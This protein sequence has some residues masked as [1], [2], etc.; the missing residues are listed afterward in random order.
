MREQRNGEAEKERVGERVPKEV[1]TWRD[2]MGE[3]PLRGTG[4]RG[5]RRAEER[6][7]G[8]ALM[9]E[10]P[11][12]LILE[13][14]GAADVGVPSLPGKHRARVQPGSFALCSS[15]ACP[16]VSMV[17]PLLGGTGTPWGCFSLCPATARGLG[18][19]GAGNW[20]PGRTEIGALWLLLVGFRASPG[21]DML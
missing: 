8:C 5:G 9:L 13:E 21:S 14:L 18:K 6:R 1:S 17:C 16:L 7:A 19:K 12:L 3:T 2:Q 11:A 4:R 15:C 20:G 10:L